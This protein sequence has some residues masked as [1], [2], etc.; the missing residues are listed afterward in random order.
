MSNTNELNVITVI[1]LD[2]DKNLDPKHS[3]VAKF[4]D[5]I[6]KEGTDPQM[7]LLEL[8]VENDVKGLLAKH[9]VKRAELFNKAAQERHGNKVALE[10]ITIRDVKVIIK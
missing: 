6:V 4:D 7:I 3:V 8:S 9:N 2:Q 1:L 5:V 10:P